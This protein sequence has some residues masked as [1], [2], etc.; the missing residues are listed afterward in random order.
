[1]VDG[2]DG[3]GKGVVVDAL[4]D[5]ALQKRLRTLDLRE[6]WK[7]HKGYPSITSY[8]V[9]ISAEPT[10]TG[11]GKRI[12][13]KL[14]S[15]DSPAYPQKIAEAFSKDREVLYRKLILPALR[16]GKHVFQ[17]R[18]V[19]TSLVYQPLQEGNS[20]ESVSS[21]AGNRFCLEYPPNLLILTV[22]RPEVVIERLG[23]RVKKDNSI[24]ETLEFQK[25][26]KKVYE[27]KWLRDIFESKGTVVSKL[28][29]NPPSTE[30]DTRRKSVKL[31]TK[32]L[33]SQA[34]G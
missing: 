13:E 5:F 27:S 2:L 7:N 20:L 8:D 17:E 1:M 11:W 22:V 10:Y 30:Q 9:I 16:A 18:G 19:V 29:T 6:Y 3:S 26:V 23:E 4:R 15:K 21:L 34:L 14:I 28:N 32:A 33:K 24:F 12:R 31:L 25:K